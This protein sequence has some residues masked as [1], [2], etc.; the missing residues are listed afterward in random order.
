M[1]YWIDFK[2][3]KVTNAWI[4][5]QGLLDP[6]SPDTSL[7]RVMINNL[8]YNNGFTLKKSK[9]KGNNDII[10]KETED[11]FII[12]VF[13]SVD[14]QKFTTNIHFDSYSKKKYTF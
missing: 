10:I 13:Y 8:L 6:N 3:E 9:L 2:N 12:G 5:K 4:F 11:S 1:N 7:I 14:E